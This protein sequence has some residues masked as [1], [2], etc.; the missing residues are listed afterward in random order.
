MSIL[1]VWRFRGREGQLR[2]GQL[3]GVEQLERDED[4]GGC[5]LIGVGALRSI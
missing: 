2:V 3:L 4:E 1:I 5:L